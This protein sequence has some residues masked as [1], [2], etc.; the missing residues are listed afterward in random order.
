MGLFQERGNEAKVRV[1]VLFYGYFEITCTYFSTLTGQRRHRPQ[2]VIK[3]APFSDTHAT[4]F[5][6]PEVNKLRLALAFD[7]P[8]ITYDLHQGEI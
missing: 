2:L 4:S 1:N 7:L 3:S 6:S 8:Q 5:L